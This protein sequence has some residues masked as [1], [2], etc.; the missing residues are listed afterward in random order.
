MSSAAPRTKFHCLG[1]P[2]EL[3]DY[4][5]K[6]FAARLYHSIK[7]KMP[8]NIQINPSYKF[9]RNFQS[10]QEIYSTSSPKFYY[11]CAVP[12]LMFTKRTDA[13]VAESVVYVCD[14]TD[15]LEIKTG[16]RLQYTKQSDIPKA[17]AQM[18]GGLHFIA[19][20]KAIKAL[21]NRTIPKEVSSNGL[22]V[23]KKD[24]MTFSLQF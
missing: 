15:L 16:G 13:S 22:L 4:D 5:D 7:E 20:A 10:L 12:D 24:G 23:N 8:A 21:K 17:F 18:V 9:A 1:H 6:D 2:F 3:K 11:F 14:D 19:T